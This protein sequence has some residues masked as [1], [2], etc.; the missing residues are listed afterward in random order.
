MT[1]ADILAWSIDWLIHRH[2]RGRA[3]DVFDERGR[4]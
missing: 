4:G 1:N 2:D 3:G